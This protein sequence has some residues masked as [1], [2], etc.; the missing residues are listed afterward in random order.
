MLSEDAFIK[1]DLFVF[2]FE[3]R[4]A[5]GYQSSTAHTDER[6]IDRTCSAPHKSCSSDLDEQTTVK[7]SNSNNYIL[8]A[9]F[10]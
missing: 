9:A 6:S 5:I 3:H 10:L 4:C 2:F 1:K 7:T 8:K